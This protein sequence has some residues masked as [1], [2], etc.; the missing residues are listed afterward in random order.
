MSGLSIGQGRS[1]IDRGVEQRRSRRRVPS[2]GRSEAPADAVAGHAPVP[3]FLNDLTVKLGHM[4][5]G[6]VDKAVRNRHR[7]HLRRAHWAHALDAS[8]LSLRGWYDPTSARERARGPDRRLRGA[9]ADG[10][11]DGRGDLARP[12][13]GMVPLARAGAQSR[14]GASGRQGA[15]RRARREDRRARAAVEGRADPGLPSLTR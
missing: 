5:G 8:A 13:D 1:R 12:H 3:G 10:G 6:S 14:G 9:A 2:T 15:A 4:L 7:R 11:G